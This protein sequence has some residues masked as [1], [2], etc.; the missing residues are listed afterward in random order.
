MDEL[1]QTSP[2]TPI[3][4]VD[5]AEGAKLLNALREEK[6]WLRI[7]VDQVSDYMFVKDTQCRFIMAN[8]AMAQDLGYDSAEDLIGRTDLELYAFPIALAFYRDAKLVMRTD[9]P[10]IDKEE[11]VVLPNGTKRWLASSKF[12]LRS[13]TGE[14]VGVF[15]ISR[16][17]TERK[18]SDRLRDGQAQVLE[19][20]SSSAPLSEALDCLVRLIEDQ[21]D[22]MLGSILLLDDDGVHL[23]HGAAPSL[24]PEYCKL[25]DGVA[26]GPKVGSCGTA[27]FRGE[28][29][30]VCDIQTDPLWQD[31]LPLAELAGVRACWSTPI[32]S[33]AGRVLGTFAIYSRQPVAPG[34]SELRLIND[35]ARI[36]AIAIE[37]K[38]AEEQIRFLAHH[39]PLTGLPNRSQLDDCLR[40]AI[41]RSD[42]LSHQVAVVF[43]D[44]DHF[45]SVNDSFGHAAGDQLLV[46][47]AERMKANLGKDGVVLRLGGDEFVLLVSGDMARQDA[48]QAFLVRLRAAIAEPV[49]IEGQTFHITCSMGIA[50]YP[51]N[52]TDADTLLVHADAAMYGAKQAGRNTFE[53]YNPERSAESPTD[54][55]LLEEIRIGLARDEFSLM[56]QPQIDL[57]TGRVLGVEALV[58]WQHPDRGLLSPDMF[59]P[60]AEEGGLINAL[61]KQVLKM[62]CRQARNWQQM[63]LPPVTMSVNVSARQFTQRGWADQVKG[64]LQKT[65]LDPSMLE[66]ELTE[67]MLMRN[68]EQAIA[69]M[70]ELCALGVRFAIDDFGTGYSSLSA[71]RSFPVSRLKIDQA[72]VRDAAED[73][74][75][76][77]IAEA[78]I[79]LGHKLHLNVI[80][81]GVETEEQLE[82]L[83]ESDCDEA[84]GFLIA[85][86]LP[87]ADIEGWIGKVWDQPDA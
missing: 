67:S 1:G 53:V 36:A 4:S 82:F 59:I 74:S 80:A 85:K 44:L 29:V 15:G 76:R 52:G 26:I 87:A 32:L 42:A 65:G 68:V 30:I 78:I 84:Q 5:N 28:Q 86:P 70:N 2:V 64:I 77:G 10:I 55:V 41:R 34:P 40:Q 22:G 14:L 24:D 8:R 63:G 12:P 19:M 31:F 33:L 21:L 23:R 72:F 7:M 43:L 81:E 83:R 60:V 47:A 62:A 35:T 18:K 51:N 45:K 71:L 25:V 79:S 6:A 61:G 49:E 17:I 16:D 50:L 37:R 13:S 39:D 75:G 20:I 66:L 11:F 69:T 58:R 48:L 57:R 9:K 46:I 3:E 38:R 73:S 27:A 56:Y 54:L